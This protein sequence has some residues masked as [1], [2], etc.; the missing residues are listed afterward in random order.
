M[1]RT[2]GFFNGW[3]VTLVFT[4][5]LGY[6][7]VKHWP[8]SKKFDSHSETPADTSAK[9]GQPGPDSTGEGVPKE[10]THA[11]PE[12]KGASRGVAGEEKKAEH[13]GSKPP[14]EPAI[15][16][17]HGKQKVQSFCQSVEFRGNGPDGGPGS[18][19]G[20]ISTEQWDRV[21]TQFHNAKK[22]LISWLDGHR[23]QFTKEVSDHMEIEVR[24]LRLQRPPTPDYPDLAI[25]GIG[26]WTRP[27]GERPIIKLGGGF[28]K[29]VERNPARARFEL[30]RLIAQTWSPCELKKSPIS[31]HLPQE[32]PWNSLVTCLGV[33]DDN[34]CQAGSFSEAG[35]AVSSALASVA[36][37]PG[38]TVPAFAPGVGDSCLKDIQSVSARLP[39]SVAIPRSKKET[40]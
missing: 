34:A 30:T 26:I 36:S 16:T 9:L 37:P 33:H 25:R 35:W 27:Q 7:A 5:A 3:V 11:K 31:S 28:A 24:E 23:Y 14:A 15:T 10:W 39:A 38:C 29:L 8:G 6:F 13:V 21:M 40:H 4:A 32:G 20:R 2:R 18:Q 17:G 12:V 1:R 19:W 22:D